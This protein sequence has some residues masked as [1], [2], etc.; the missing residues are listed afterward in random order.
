MQAFEGKEKPRQIE[1]ARLNVSTMI[2]SKRKLRKIVESGVVSGWDDPRMPTISGIR[3]RGYTP[4]SLQK[5][6]ELIGV[7]KSDNVVDISFL[8]YCIREDLKGKVPRIMAVI[9]PVKV[10]LTN[11]PENKI[12]YVTIENNP[13]DES[14]GTRQVPFGRNLYIEREDFMENPV[15]K[16]FRMT[17]GKE[18]RLKGAYIVRCDEVIKDEKER[19]QEIHCTVDF[20]TRSGTPG[21]DRK[22]KGTLHWVCADTSVDITSRLY[23]YLIDPEDKDDG[24][25]FMEKINQDSLEIFE[26][27]AEPIIK[28]YQIGDRFQFLRKGYFIIDQDSSEGHLIC[29]RIVGLRDTWAKLQKKQ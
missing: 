29:N 3:R 13:E 15:K 2:T 10:V 27:K 6:C 21:A 9:D 11:Y 12:E 26:G 7:A 28:E 25:D 1:F 19:I 8:E 4:E 5:F 22:V 16:F 18:V 24:R 17:P 14:M 20:D 23:D